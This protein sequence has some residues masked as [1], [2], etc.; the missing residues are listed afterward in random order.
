MLEVVVRGRS[1]PLRRRLIRDMLAGMADKTND[2]TNDLTLEEA[3]AA[4]PVLRRELGAGKEGRDVARL[5]SELRRAG[6]A[7]GSID[8]I[9]GDRTATAI[10]EFAVRNA[11]PAPAGVV[12]AALWAAILRA[13]ASAQADAHEAVARAQEQAAGA[14]QDAA[15][16]LQKVAVDKRAQ[17]QPAG[18][19]EEMAAAALLRA[20]Q[21]WRAAADS[22]RAAATVLAP[23]ADLEAR[24]VR[25]Y[26]RQLRAQ[27]LAR[28]L[29]ARVVNSVALAGRDLDAGGGTEHRERLA[30]ATLTAR[31]LA[32][33]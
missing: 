24:G 11:L 16:A 4:A 8:G 25:A 22:W 7:P 21:Q 32:V 33:E 12:D 14:P 29:A 15:T 2:L 5:Q 13:G 10:Q 26:A 17:A 27:D 30:A 9:F 3:R 23:H 6:L 1:R 20:A 28:S 18:A 31:L 19:D